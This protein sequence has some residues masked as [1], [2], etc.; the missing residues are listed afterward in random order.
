MP[1]T[2]DIASGS[3]RGGAVVVTGG[4]GGRGVV[5]LAGVWVRLY[6]W[7]FSRN[8]VNSVASVVTGGPRTVWSNGSSWEL[9]VSDSESGLF[10]CSRSY[11][12]AHSMIRWLLLSGAM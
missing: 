5:C 3:D 1:W 12:Q 2:A 6:V 7:T 8:R 9:P 4:A 11:S 10:A